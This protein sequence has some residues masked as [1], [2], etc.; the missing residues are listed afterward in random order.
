VR[1][2]PV[3][4]DLLF[5]TPAGLLLDVWLALPSGDAAGVIVVLVLVLTLAVLLWRA[6]RQARWPDGKP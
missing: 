1:G 2:R 3:M 6:R 5:G 4:R